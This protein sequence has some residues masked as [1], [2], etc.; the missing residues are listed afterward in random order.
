MAGL[1]QEGLDFFTSK[2]WE[3]RPRVRR[4]AFIYGTLVVSAIALV[5]AV[6]VSIGIAL[7]IT[8]VAPLRLRRPIV[9]VIDLLAAVPSVVYGLWGILVLRPTLPGFYARHRTTSLRQHPA[10]RHPVL[11]EPLSGVSFMTAG[12]ILALMITPIITSITREVFATVPTAQK[13]AA[14]RARRDALGDDPGRGVP[15]QPAGWSARCFGLGRAMGETIAVA[16]VIGSATSITADLFSPGDTMAAVIVNQFGEATGTYRAALIGLGV[17]LF[18]ITIVIGVVARGVR[19]PRRR[20]ERRAHDAT[21]APPIPVTRLGPASEA[22]SRRDS[23]RARDDLHRLVVPRRAGAAGPHH[24]LRR[25]A[26]GT[27]C[28]ATP[29]SPRRSRSP[30]SRGR[31]WGRRSSERC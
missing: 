28:S 1:P 6:P 5:I 16:L 4:A 14:R 11:G 21:I 19:R 2:T 7:F 27:R 17:V 13:E 29:S 31:A 25:R 8:E 26:A 30:R 23:Q 22:P 3:S 24:R 18:A 15:A 9:Y 12:L 20:A 10:P